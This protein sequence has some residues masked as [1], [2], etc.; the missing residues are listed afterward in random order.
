MNT[1]AISSPHSS[2]DCFLAPQQRADRLAAGA[3]IHLADAGRPVPG[4]A[5]FIGVLVQECEL[6]LML[7]IGKGTAEIQKVIIGCCLLNRFMPA[8]G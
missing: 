4:Q 3:G 7:L 6:V 8:T 5:H 1:R 2:P